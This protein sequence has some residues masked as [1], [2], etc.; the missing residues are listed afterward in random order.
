MNID[1]KCWNFNT[2]KDLILPFE[3]SLIMEIPITNSSKADENHMAWHNRWMLLSEIWVS[4]YSRM[5]G[6]IIDI[7]D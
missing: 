4:S 5:E 3:A 2:V 1:N 6:D 7:P